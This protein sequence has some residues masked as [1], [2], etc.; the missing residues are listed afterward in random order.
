M[1]G[2]VAWSNFKQTLLG[3]KGRGQESGVMTSVSTD[4]LSQNLCVLC[5]SVANLLKSLQLDI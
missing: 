3:L 2:K 5:A 4:L 1:R